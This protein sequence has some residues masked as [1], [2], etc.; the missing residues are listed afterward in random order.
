M[1][2]QHGFVHPTEWVSSDSVDF[3]NNFDE[4]KTAPEDDDVEDTGESEKEEEEENE[5]E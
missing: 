1:H 5:E 4:G 2:V 3:G